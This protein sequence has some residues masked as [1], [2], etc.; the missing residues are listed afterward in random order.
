M[1]HYEEGMNAMWEEVEGKRSE[2]FHQPSEEERGKKLIEE[3]G[4]SN[5]VLQTEFGIIDISEDAMRNR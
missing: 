2:P 5:A 4:R 3:Y 1:N